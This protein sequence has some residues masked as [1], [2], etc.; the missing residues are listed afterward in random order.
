MNSAPKISFWNLAKRNFVFYLRS[1]I[2][3]AAGCAI[4]AT[5]LIGALLIGTSLKESLHRLHQPRLGEIRWAINSSAG[6]FRESIADSIN[7]YLSIKTAPILP[8]SG[9]VWVTG[10]SAGGLRVN[11]VGVDERFWELGASGERPQNFD[12]GAFINSAVAR[13]LNIGPGDQIILRF[14]T[15]GS[16]AMDAPFGLD[17]NLSTLNLPITS[18]ID[19]D[20]FGDFSL[21][22]EHFAVYNVFV[23]LALL[24]T[25]NDISEIVPMILIGESTDKS[26]Q[27]TNEKIINTIQKSLDIKD[28]G[29]NVRVV[30][31]YFEI[32]SDRVFIND[33]LRDM[34]INTVPDAIPV[35]TWFVNSI[36]KEGKST[37]YSFVSTMPIRYGQQLK[38]DQIIL[39]EWIADDLGAKIGDTITLTYFVPRQTSGLR[40]DTSTFVVSAIHNQDTSAWLNRSLMPP[41]PGLADAG[42]CMDWNPSIPVD[43]EKI[44]IKDEIY[45][46]RYGGTPK[47]IIAYETA[48]RIWD[49]RFGASTA[50]RL[51]T[52]ATA[53][54][55]DSLTPAICGIQLTNV[56]ANI[57]RAVNNGI[58]FAPLFIG[59]SF[60]TFIAALL[61]IWLLSTLQIKS[62]ESEHKIL[63]ALGY[64]KKHI[65]QIYLLEGLIIFLIGIAAAI[66]L[67]PLYAIAII[68]LKT[69]WHAAIQMPELGLHID[70]AS[71]L[72]GGK[73]TLI[74]SLIAMLIPV[75]TSMKN[76]GSASIHRTSIRRAATQTFNKRRFILLNILREKK[77]AIGE[78][79][80]LACALFVLGTTQLFHSHSHTSNI[81]SSGTGGFTFYGEFNSGIPLEE[82]G[83]D[84]LRERGI[85]ANAYDSVF[86]SFAMRMKDGDD[87]S[88][89]NLNQTQSPV[90]LGAD[91][92][93]LDS[94][95]AFS[96]V[97]TISDVDKNHPWRILGLPTSLAVEDGRPH[98]T[99]YIYGVADANT[100]TWGLGKSIGDT[101]L[102]I[103]E[104]GD[105]LNIILAA[106]LKNSILQGKVIIA[107]SDFIRHYPS[108]SGYRLLLISASTYNEKEIREAFRT[109]HGKSGLLYLEETS[110]RL[111]AFNAVENTYLSIFALLG[112]MGLALGCVGLGIVIARNI[113]ERRHEFAIL[114]VQ[115]FRI[116]EIRRMLF[117]EHAAVALAGT[118]AGL[119]PAIIAFG[120]T[121]DIRTL[122]RIA[123]LLA[124]VLLCGMSSIIWG[125]RRLKGN[126]LTEILKRE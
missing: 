56:R 79:A 91:Q 57:D 19:R 71:I 1:N 37:P 111:N 122:L 86:L 114:T 74:C 14:Q 10:G 115:G 87:A 81:R 34:I 45:W 28:A 9:S 12:G 38:S 4:S 36:G 80:I 77:R 73:I 18:I 62:R 2:L 49:N 25:A 27:I 69:V 3:F 93:F 8:M 26:A 30:G 33:P 52:L 78:I 113:E 75:L 48:E 6:F 96:F 116:G 61:L 68:S 32:Y 39:S 106:A 88:C 109:Y 102:Y 101:L 42:S 100:I 123:S 126:D 67:A 21:R 112:M 43:L 92:T 13:K 85:D 16:L 118:L 90:L 107:E 120:I 24:Q 89:L 23:P 51:P 84:F 11:I 95:G 35:S 76:K 119:L 110:Q 59:L 105:T 40:I 98:R 7:T 41:Y 66:P 82:T 108:I 99:S 54:F 117:A 50:I 31:D 63:M 47:A 97:S 58:D 72:I 17:E 83:I 64:S 124:I 60:F 15:A 65:L 5:I 22:A 44:R 94:I 46:D 104:L 125:L 29:L 70:M 55:L 20:G 53:D 121:A 103:N